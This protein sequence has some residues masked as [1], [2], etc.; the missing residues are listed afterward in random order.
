MQ[1]VTVES[2]T[3][4]EIIRKLNEVLEEVKQKHKEQPLS[5]KWLDNFDVCRLLH[6]STRTLQKYR[7]SGVIPFSQYGNKIYYKA[8]DIEKFLE[9]N[10]KS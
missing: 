8:S 9:D 2:E 4:Q 7:D 6:I 1:V 5:E 3:F 10:Y